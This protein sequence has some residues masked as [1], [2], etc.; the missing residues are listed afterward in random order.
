M[1][2]RIFFPSDVT[3][4]PT[5]PSNTYQ[6]SSVIIQS[7]GLVPGCVGVVIADPHLGFQGLRMSAKILPKSHFMGSP[8]GSLK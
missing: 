8:T 4:S 3:K 7:R 2:Q 5:Q 1:Q 6:T